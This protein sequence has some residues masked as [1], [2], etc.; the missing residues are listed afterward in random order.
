MLKVLLYNRVHHFLKFLL[1]YLGHDRLVDRVPLCKKYTHAASVRNKHA[2]QSG[3][4]FITEFLISFVSGLYE[5]FSTIL[6]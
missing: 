5:V 4:T 1:V 3:C 6:K 2:Q